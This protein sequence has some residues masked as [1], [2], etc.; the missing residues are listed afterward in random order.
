MVIGSPG[1]GNLA[2]RVP[3]TPRPQVGTATAK[4]FTLS[5]TWSIERPRRSSARPRLAYSS[6]RAASRAAFSRSI[7]SWG[8]GGRLMERFMSASGLPRE[9]LGVAGVDVEDVAGRF[10]SAVGGQER[11]RLGHVLRQ[12]LAL[13][14]AAVAVVR[15][16]RLS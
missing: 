6:C 9:G 15:L 3:P 12:H 10:G 11:H 4:A 2:K 13:E 14:Q 8:R 1:I 16:Q 7:R 5:L